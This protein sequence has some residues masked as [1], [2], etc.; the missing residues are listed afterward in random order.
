MALNTS[1]CGINAENNH[2]PER[3]HPRLRLEPVL[4]TPSNDKASIKVQYLSRF[5]QG[6]KVL[7]T[8]SSLT[9][10]LDTCY[11]FVHCVQRIMLCSLS[12]P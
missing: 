3:R 6:L 8:Q 1:R 11:R 10:I 4:G 7:I 12:G 2:K 5:F 9:Q